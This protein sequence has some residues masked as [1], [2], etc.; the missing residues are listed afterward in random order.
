MRITDT[1]S[2]TMQW[3]TFTYPI[4]V[5]TP[6]S[7]AGALANSASAIGIIPRTISAKPQA[8]GSVY[9]M[10][11]GSVDLSELAYANLSADAMQAMHGIS[12][13][14]SDGTPEADPVYGI[15]AA[16]ETAIGGV[17]MAANVPDAEGEA[18]TAAEFKVLLDALKDAG[19]M[20]PD[21]DETEG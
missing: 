13:F 10:T 21:E 17:K 20:E 5:G 11:G 15:T 1:T 8:D 19:I 12:F 4:V 3:N 9:L 2:V 6:I 18:P 14:G 16:T 7:K